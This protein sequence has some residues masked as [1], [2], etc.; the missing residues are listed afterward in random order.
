MKTQKIFGLRSSESSAGEILLTRQEKALSFISNRKT[1]G[2]KQGEIYEKAG[3]EKDARNFCQAAEI[4][5]DLKIKPVV[6]L[7]NNTG[8]ADDLRKF[9]VEISGVKDMNQ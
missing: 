8:K 5:R 2:I 7:T 9:G 3:F 4:L 6:L 1:T